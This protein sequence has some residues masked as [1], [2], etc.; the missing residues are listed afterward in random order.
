MRIDRY[1]D[2]RALGNVF[3]FGIYGTEVIG[4]LRFG[5][6]ALR[7][8]VDERESNA[9]MSVSKSDIFICHKPIPAP[10]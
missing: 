5:L 2:D 9:A 10:L 1:V 7:T 6:M 4:R 3:E 8:L